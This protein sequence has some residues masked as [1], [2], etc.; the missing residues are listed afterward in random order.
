MPTTLLVPAIE[1]RLAAFI[2]MNRRAKAAATK[3]APKPTI[4]ISREFGCEGYPLAEEL[5]KLAEQATGEPWALVDKSLMDAVARDHKLSEDILHSLGQK[6]RWLDEMLSMLSPRWKNE[7]DQYK[8]MCEQIVSVAKAGNAIIVGMGGAILTQSLENCYQFRLVAS[9]EF[10]VRSIA[11]RMKISKQDADLYVEERQK[12][13][14][15]FVRSFLNADI[16][17]AHYYHMIFN[18]AKI[19]TDRIARTIADFVL[20]Q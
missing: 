8:L 7:A 4:T 1:Q 15:R 13:R 14:D 9:Q 19:R 12:E 5:K 11:H 6:P 10:K 20:K 2:E 17:D 3:A 16:G 18:N